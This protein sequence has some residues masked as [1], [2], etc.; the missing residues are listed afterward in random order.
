M[1]A[2]VCSIAAFATRDYRKRRRIELDLLSMGA[3]HVGFDE[4]SDPE[5]VA[6]VEPVRSSRIA[7]YELIGHLDLAGADV[8][9][10]SIKH[11]AKLKRV[12]V[13]HLTDTNITDDQLKMLAEIGGIQIL[14]LNGSKVTD[15]AIP[16][17]ASINGLI[18]VDLSG[19]LITRDGVA[20]LRRRVPSITVAL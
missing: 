2:I 11:I 1:L 17:I 10:A 14:R 3:Y 20:D 5:Y 12:D 7:T 4:N 8:T 16:Y 18:S 15:A 9:D 13:V 6:F 19:T